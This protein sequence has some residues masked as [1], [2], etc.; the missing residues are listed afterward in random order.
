MRQN[1]KRLLIYS[2]PKTGKTTLVS[3]LENCFILDLERGS[4]FLECISLPA[5]NIEDIKTI[6]KAIKE[7]NYPYSYFVIDTVT[8]LEEMCLPLALDLYKQTPMGRAFSGDN[9]LSLP[10]GAGY[11]WL[12]EAFSKVLNYLETLAPT[13]I[14]LGHVLDKVVEVKGKEVNASD[15]DLTGKLKRIACQD[16]DAIGFLYRDGNNTYLN[17]NS[18]DTVTC[19]ARPDHLKG[20]NILLGEGDAQGNLISTHWEKIFLN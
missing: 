1:P 2:K 4:E 14:M 5:D 12:R 10:N 17:F 3:K 7:A 11:Y 13:I 9:V 15:I 16:A 18:S 20:Q 19:G 8:K 6:G